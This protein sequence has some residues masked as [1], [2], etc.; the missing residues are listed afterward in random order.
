MDM[1]ANRGHRRLAATALGI[2]MLLSG[3][4]SSTVYAQDVSRAETLIF[5][6][7][8]ERIA[9]PENYNPFLP[10]TTLQGGL[11]Q[12]GFESLFYLNLESG[13]L[14]PW[15][16]ESYAFNDTFDEVTITLRDGIMWS[17]GEPFTADDVVFTMN[18]LKE[19]SAALGVWGG[20]AATWIEDVVAVDPLNVKF[21]LTGTNPSFVVNTFGARVWRVNHIIPQH[22]WENQDPTT[23]T[24]FDIAQGWPVSTSPY[25]LAASNNQETIWNLRETWWGADTGFKDMPD[26][27][28]I[29]FT[30]AGNEERRVAMLINND[31]DTAYSIG[32]NSFETVHAANP[33]I[34][35][36]L[37]E[38]PYAYTDAGPRVLMFNNA[39]PPFDDVLVRQAASYAVNRE[40]LVDIAWEGMSRPIEW[41]TPSYPA[42]ATYFEGTEDLFEANPTNVYD[43]ERTAELMA[44][45]GYTKDGGGFW[46]DETGT[47]L[48]LDIIG[49]QTEADSAK[50][51]PVVTELLRRAGFDAQFR[52]ID[53]GAF[54]DAVYLG[55]AKIW[56]AGISGG[57]TNPYA[58]FELFHSRHA[59]DI[60]T[61]STGSNSRWVSTEFDAVVDQM[62]ALDPSDPAFKDL[63]REGL[64]IWL[65]EL[66]VAPL[67]DAA[68]LASYNNTYW[69][70][71]PTSDD[72]YIQPTFWWA[73]ALVSILN[74]E[75]ASN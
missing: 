16:A 38:M 56:L 22:I 45:A 26:P 37:D 6:S 46:A 14:E 30:S 67:T 48:V 20:N 58:T 15:Q 39:V 29:I 71:W 4:A 49:R 64:E 27:K 72:P 23:F 69:T 59:A 44:E 73:N 35:T 41:V 75:P 54:Y 28:R 34:V 7:T 63:V 11:H 47:R 42:L 50:A 18:M 17:D 43:P 25:Q 2:G 13:E 1:L 3:I 53:S 12:L 8:L 33:N 40:A 60:G 9:T 51:A 19:N 21:T 10:S 74:I 31:L 5:D 52:L 70:G 55:G 36:W 24:N 68:L 65:P 66:P 32:K 61:P 62:S 57:V